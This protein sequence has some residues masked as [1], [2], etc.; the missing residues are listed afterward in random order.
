MVSVAVLREERVS[1]IRAVL[2]L[3]GISVGGD[4][5]GS[6]WW[7]LEHATKIVV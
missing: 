2:L 1:V 6:G 3:Y 4:G 7:I 5:G